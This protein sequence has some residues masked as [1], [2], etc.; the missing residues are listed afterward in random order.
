MSSHRALLEIYDDVE[1]EL[2]SRGY[3]CRACG[4]CCD[5]EANDYKL[6]ASQI[7]KQLVIEKA[8]R[9]PVLVNGCCCFLDAAGKCTI[10]AWRPLGCRTYFCD[11]AGERNATEELHER[12]LAR[13]KETATR[14]ETGWQYG[15]FFA[16]LFPSFFGAWHF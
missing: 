13:I 15:W 9:R 1:R 4:K 16:S 7:E 6:Y 12:A 10:H 3:A 14:H 5:F 2:T 8:G 11:R